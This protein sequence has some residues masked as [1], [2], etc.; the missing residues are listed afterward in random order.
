M[1]SHP[2]DAVIVNMSP[3][4]NRDTLNIVRFVTETLLQPVLLEP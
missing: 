2:E 1:A 4:Q 3:M